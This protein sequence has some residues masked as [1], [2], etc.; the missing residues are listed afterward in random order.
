MTK[1]NRTNEEWLELVSQQRASGLTTAAWCQENN[2]KL[3]TFADRITRLRKLGLITEPKPPGGRHCERRTTTEI[4]K[5]EQ[6]QTTQ[7]LEVSPLPLTDAAIEKKELR[8]KIGEFEIFVSPTFEE[9]V[10]VRI[11]KALTSI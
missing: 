11:C 1:R 10:F 9:T 4:L 3:P 2:I 5:Y 7:W 6:L 8:V